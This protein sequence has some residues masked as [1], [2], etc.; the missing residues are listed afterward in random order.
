MRLPDELLSCV[1]FLAVE[2]GSEGFLY[3]GTGFFVAVPTRPDPLRHFVYLVTA[4]HCVDRASERGPLFLR[5]NTR[6]GGAAWVKVTS[7]WRFPENPGCDLAVL[8][9]WVPPDRFAYRSIDA[10]LLATEERIT[11]VGLGIGD[12]LAVIGLFTRRCGQKRNLPIA[13]TG[14]IAAMPDEPLEDEQTG[15]SYNAYIA[16]IRSIGGLSGSPVFAVLGPARP[17]KGAVNLGLRFLLV[18]LIRG[19]WDYRTGPR[20]AF[21]E[22]ELEQV[23][24]GMAIVTPASELFA[25]LHSAPLA[26][27]RCRIERGIDPKTQ[28]AQ[29]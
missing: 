14:I 11:E 13:R 19:H 1:C 24:M 28:A 21:S 16:E 7:Q 5:L 4:R 3:G 10:E 26:D 15:C 27:E 22:N 12:E 18:G 6:A 25:L 23:N 29:P 2:N 9:P 17:L 8:G 20:L